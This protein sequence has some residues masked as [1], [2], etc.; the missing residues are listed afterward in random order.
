MTVSAS[1]NRIASSRSRTRDELTR[2]TFD[3]LVVGGGILG[4]SVA[5]TATQ[6]GLR[7]AM[8]DSGD[9]AGA[10]SSASSKL[11]H[12]GLRYLQS[13]QVRLVAENH[14]ERRS[15]ASEVAPHLVNHMPFLVPIYSGGPHG[16]AKMGAGVFLYSALSAF[17]DG[18]G[19]LLSPAQAR[20]LAPGLRTDGLRSVA[21][22]SD[23]QMSDSR[24]AVMSIIT[25][26]MITNRGP[27]HFVSNIQG[28]GF[29]EIPEPAL[30]GLSILNPSSQTTKNKKH[31]HCRNNLQY[32]ELRYLPAKDLR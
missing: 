14:R 2:G 31:N 27:N 23:H 3:L 30:R 32:H 17:G 28:N 12:G 10:T 9:F 4:T 15:L 5:W 21:A 6:A 20:R 19:R 22:Y 11:V 24:M 16:A 13:G 1:Q 18:M 29:P 25:M 7:V 26:P 8:V